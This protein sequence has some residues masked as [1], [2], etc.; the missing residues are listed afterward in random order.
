MRTLL[1]SFIML[2]VPTITEAQKAYKPLKTAL[3]DKNY[4][5]A[6]AQIKK[7]RAD[8]TYRLDPKLCTYG[9]EAYRGLNDAENMKV[10]LKQNCDTVALFSTTYQIV[11]EAVML[12]SLENENKKNK[13]EKP[14][15]TKFVSE[16][17]QRYYPNL[18]VAARFFYKKQN[19][20]EAMRYL[21]YCIDL[22]HTPLGAR[23]HLSTT[24]DVSNAVLYLSSAFTTKNYAE[25]HR[26]ENIALCDSLSR[27]SVMKYLARTAEAENDTLAYERMLRQGWK[28]G[29][30]D[31]SF[32]GLLVD[33]YNLHKEYGH[34]LNVAAQHIKVHPQSA[35]AYMAQSVAYFKQQNFDK[36][37]ASA[38]KWLEC[39][40]LSADAHYYIGASYVYKVDEVPMEGPINSLSY[41]QSLVKRGELYAKAE[42]ELEAYRQMMPKAKE[43]WAPLLYKVYLALNNGEK[44][45]EIEEILAE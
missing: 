9:I 16:M 1:L 35:I 23:S 41:R 31:E 21:R 6:V 20:Q 43:E 5:E 19:F 8:S 45:A 36:C 14:R 42:P 40:S 13:G 44:F 17:L 12:D 30:Y 39:D 38:K 27:K 15:E 3:K 32:F 28:N 22:P 2:L 26:Y 18:N 34:T 10:Y 11:K 37:I 29:N 4:K 25:V 7:L 33:F 24:H